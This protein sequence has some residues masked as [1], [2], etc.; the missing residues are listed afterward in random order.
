MG[1]CFGGLIVSGGCPL[2]I[3]SWVGVGVV[4]HVVVWEWSSPFVGV[5]GPFG[6]SIIVDWWFG[7]GVMSSS[8]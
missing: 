5:C 8:L 4:C 1:F 2:K 7:M 6:V 3:C